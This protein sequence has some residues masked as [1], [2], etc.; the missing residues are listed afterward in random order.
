[1]LK[2]SMPCGCDPGATP[3]HECDRHTIDRLER[4]IAELK[5]AIRKI[6]FEARV[7]YLHASDGPARHALRLIF[8][9]CKA[10]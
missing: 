2:T 1:M 8:G 6:D 7:A 9:S 5:E 10:L 4:E 3:A